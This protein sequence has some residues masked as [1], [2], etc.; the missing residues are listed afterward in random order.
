MSLTVKILQS[1]CNCSSG[2]IRTEIEAA[3]SEEGIAVTIEETAD[4]QEAI[5]YGTTVFPSLVINGE[6]Y[7]YDNVSG[8]DEL[9]QLLNE[10]K[11][12]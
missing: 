2:S 8:F 3:A 12:Q 5:K 6:V 11:T 7:G 10:N 1:S 4:L 9:K